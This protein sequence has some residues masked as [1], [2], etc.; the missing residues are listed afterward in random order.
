MEEWR[1]LEDYPDYQ[2]SSKGRVKNIHTGRILSQEISRNGYPTIRI[3]DKNH[4]RMHKN[5][6]L[7]IA[8]AFLG[9]P[10]QCINHIDGN[11]LNNNVENLE[12]CTYSHNNQHAYDMGLKRARGLTSEE[13]KA[14]RKKVDNSL[15]CRP[16]ID[17]TTGKRYKAIKDTK[18]DGFS[19]IHVQ[20]VCSGDH[21]THQ[22]HV[23]VYE[24][25]EAI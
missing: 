7:M 6:H 17:L 24:V 16:V 9:E 18:E 5:T 13:A 19:P 10:N 1:S 15:K 22:G 21:K 2:F 8:L 20:R 11:K 25:K 14:M 4:K 3:F 12:W 23:F